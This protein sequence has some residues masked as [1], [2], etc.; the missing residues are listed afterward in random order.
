M[1][2]LRDAIGLF[3]Y[4]SFISKASVWPSWVRV[5]VCMCVWEVLTVSEVKLEEIRAI[6]TVVEVFGGP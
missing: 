6:Y 5:C 1:T 4:V 3:V 2:C